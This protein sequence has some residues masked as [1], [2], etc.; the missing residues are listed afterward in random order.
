MAEAIVVISTII[1]IYNWD[2]IASVWM[3]QMATAESL[4]K[5]QK[6]ILG[7]IPNSTMECN[8]QKKKKQSN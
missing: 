5:L 3:F 1:Y 4:V 2:H 8:S 6:M 7:N